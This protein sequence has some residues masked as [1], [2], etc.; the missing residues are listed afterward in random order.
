[1]ILLKVETDELGVRVS[2]LETGISIP[3][4]PMDEILEP[5]NQLDDSSTRKYAD[6]GLGLAYVQKIIEAQ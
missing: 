2:V 6:T 4:E 3:D 5:F 1:M